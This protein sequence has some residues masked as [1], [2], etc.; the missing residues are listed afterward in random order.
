MSR[1]CLANPL[2]QSAI[3]QGVLPFWTSTG[4]LLREAW[5]RR[6]Y[7]LFLLQNFDCVL[8]FWV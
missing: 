4:L 7:N 5:L 8:V 6:R 2:S 3:G 1:S